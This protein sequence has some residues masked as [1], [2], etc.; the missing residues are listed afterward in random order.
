[1]KAENQIQKKKTVEDKIRDFQGAERWAKDEMPSQKSTENQSDIYHKE[2]LIKKYK[3]KFS[4]S[5]IIPQEE[6]STVRL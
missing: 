4:K 6:S 5:V 3:S 1:M 2:M